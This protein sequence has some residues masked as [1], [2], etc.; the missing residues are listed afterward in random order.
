MVYHPV[1]FRRVRLDFTSHDK[2]PGVPVGRQQLRFFT[3]LCTSAYARHALCPGL[4]FSTYLSSFMT[5]NRGV[6]RRVNLGRSVARVLLGS[7]RGSHRRFSQR[8]FPTHVVTVSIR[9]MAEHDRLCH[10][11][12]CWTYMGRG[13]CRN[14]LCASQW[15]PE[16]RRR[17]CK[18]CHSLSYVGRKLCLN[19]DCTRALEYARRSNQVE[20]WR[21]MC[22]LEAARV[23]E[24]RQQASDGLAQGTS[25]GNTTNNTR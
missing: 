7:F 6:C 4:S 20:W 5:T 2:R 17:L 16:T 24:A 25:S 12:G 11:C 22:A 19:A 3:P 13:V 14:Q 15:R 8:S 1:R 23:Q 10:Q 9:H 21:N 18:W